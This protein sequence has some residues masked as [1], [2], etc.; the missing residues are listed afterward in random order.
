MMLQDKIHQ[1]TLE[2]RHEL[3]YDRGVN[4]NIVECW[5]HP[6]GSVH[7]VLSDRAE[8]SLFIGPGGRVVAELVKRIQHP[9]AI[10]GQEEILIRR[11]RLN[12]TLKR[13]QEIRADISKTQ[14]R[15]LD[16]L[17]EQVE[18]E[19]I[20]P[21]PSDEK[22]TAQANSVKIAVAYSGGVDSGASLIL[23][24]S[25]FLETEAVTVD[26]GYKMLG[27]HEKKKITERL[28]E[29]GISQTFIKPTDGLESVIEKTS[30]GRIHP[31]G[32]C[33]KI[34]MDSVREHAIENGYDVLVTG[35]MLPTG[36]Q[37]IE[38]NQNLMI[39]HVPATLSLSKHRTTQI[40][41]KLPNTEY[42]TKFGCHLLSE[43][44]GRGWSSINPSIYRVLRELQGGVLS[45]GKALGQIRSILNPILERRQ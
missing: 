44:H 16:F 32:P 19:L 20:H 3:G 35:E 34:T 13:I 17:T 36:R 2:I 37:S 28:G 6:D 18:R 21:A 10:Y 43:A 4:P 9:V 8:K 15:F 14:N 27:E 42:S 29:L 31:C 7:I 38:T 1:T 39:V 26:L 33:H 23:T 11:H 40:N 25:A 12:L 45:T 22:T 41:K 30:E 24:K 5:E